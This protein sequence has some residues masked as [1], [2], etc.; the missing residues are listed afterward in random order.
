MIVARP[1]YQLAKPVLRKMVD[2]RQAGVV[3]NGKTAV[4]HCEKTARGNPAHFGDEFFLACPR[5]DMFQDGVAVDNV[6]GV[7]IKRKRLTGGYLDMR[8]FRI[9]G[10]D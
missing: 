2:E 3:F 1:A 9:G 10:E 6:E 5:T 8:H 4:G 7:G